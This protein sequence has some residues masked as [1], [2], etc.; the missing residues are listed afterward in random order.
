MRHESNN[1]KIMNIHEE[2]F[3]LNSICCAYVTAIILQSFFPSSSSPLV[4]KNST[5]IKIRN[6]FIHFS[7]ALSIDLASS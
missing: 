6:F 1:K 7:C 5:D 2:N 4:P 3:Y